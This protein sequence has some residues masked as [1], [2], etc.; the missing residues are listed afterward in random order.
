MIYSRIS[1]TGSYLPRRVVTNQELEKQVDTT[2]DWIV[3]R[4]GIRERH[5]IG[6]GEGTYCA[7]PFICGS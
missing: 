1:G 3:S 4:T 7:Y 2:D 5:I 6:E